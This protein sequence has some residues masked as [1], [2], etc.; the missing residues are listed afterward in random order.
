VEVTNN[1]DKRSDFYIEVVVQVDGEPVDAAN[2]YVSA[3]DPGET[4]VGDA[5][6]GKD[7]PT[8]AKFTVSKV[9]RSVAGGPAKTMPP[10]VT[11]DPS[12]PVSTGRWQGH[13][14]AGMTITVDFPAEVR[15]DPLRGALEP[16]LQTCTRPRTTAVVQLDN[17]RHW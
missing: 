14:S 9:Q 5:A 10:L 15:D 16:A 12:A 13:S 1:S 3:L 11:E 4:D 8:N 7:L 17:Q 2:V 6:F